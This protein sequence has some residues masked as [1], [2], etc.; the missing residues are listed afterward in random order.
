SRALDTVL[1][2]KSSTICGSPQAARPT[3][4]PAQTRAD[5]GAAK[6]T[7]V[8][9]FKLCRRTGVLRSTSFPINRGANA[10]YARHCRTPAPPSPPC[11]RPKHAKTGSPQE[12]SGSRRRWP[13]RK[14]ADDHCLEVREPDADLA[15]GGLRRIGA[16][17]D[18]LRDLEGEVTA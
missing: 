14:P 17:D 4:R 1:S 2:L 3:R 5:P 7:I 18:V 16:V 6:A 13:R 8:V 12:N 15:L 9:L 11:A 10:A